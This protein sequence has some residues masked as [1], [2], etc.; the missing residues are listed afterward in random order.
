MTSLLLKNAGNLV[1][2]DSRFLFYVE[3]DQFNI[4]CALKLPTSA[5]K[6][7]RNNNRKSTFSDT[8]AFIYISIFVMHDRQI[9]WLID[10]LKSFL[11]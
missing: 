11:N 10:W 3:Q 4:Q 5:I 2:F 8:E 6:H 1:I 7:L 9:D